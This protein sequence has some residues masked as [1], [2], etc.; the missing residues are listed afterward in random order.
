MRRARLRYDLELEI[1]LLNYLILLDL[2]AEVHAL[3]NFPLLHEFPDRL[4]IAVRAI[5]VQIQILKVVLL[6]L[7]LKL[8]QIQLLVDLIYLLMRGADRVS[9]DRC[10][11][12]SHSR[13]V[14]VVLHMNRFLEYGMILQSTLV[15]PRVRTQAEIL[16]RIRP[17]H[18]EA[19][20]SLLRLCGQLSVVP[21]VLLRFGALL[22]RPEVDKSPIQTCSRFPR[23]ESYFFMSPDG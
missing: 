21:S 22:V 7:F 2:V 4:L 1:R 8:A 5:S 15:Q 13:P 14:L 16:V 6:G 18:V 20:F 3:E 11:A 10:V 23:P 12:S 9:L 19:C 17:R